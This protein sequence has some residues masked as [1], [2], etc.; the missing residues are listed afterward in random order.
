MLLLL[1][2][3]VALLE[4]ITANAAI[5]TRFLTSLPIDFY[6]G[7]IIT[8]VFLSTFSYDTFGAQ[9]LTSNVDDLSNVIIVQPASIDCG[10][11]T[12]SSSS[13]TSSAC[14]VATFIAYA[15]GCGVVEVVKVQRLEEI[16]HVKRL[17][18]RDILSKCVTAGC[19]RA[20]LSIVY[21]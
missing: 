4:T 11:T 17:K 20:K 14:P 18:V 8:K 13:A 19:S 1:L 9:P 15:V 3:L 10:G 2:L 16:A 6:E 12:R 21:V 5:A 7:K